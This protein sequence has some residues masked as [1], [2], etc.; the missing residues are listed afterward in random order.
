MAADLL[1]GWGEP[2]TLEESGDEFIRRI[3]ARREHEVSPVAPRA[4]AMAMA[5][6][7]RNVTRKVGA[8]G[9]PPHTQDVERRRLSRARDLGRPPREA[10]VRVAAIRLRPGEPRHV[11]AGGGRSRL[12]TD[13]HAR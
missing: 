1:V 13:G 8:P 2:P 5:R 3:L 7:R 12:E 6:R 4:R 10:R 11:A 9:R